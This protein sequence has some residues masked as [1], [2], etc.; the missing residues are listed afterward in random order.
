MSQQ[1]GQKL[2]STTSFNRLLRSPKPH[3][4]KQHRGKTNLTAGVPAIV[5]A[6][7]V[8]LQQVILNLIVNAWKP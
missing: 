5:M 8:Q 1:H 4:F 2:I 3:S 7:A 6:D